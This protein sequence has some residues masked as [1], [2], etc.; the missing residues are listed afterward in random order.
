MFPGTG[1]DPDPANIAPFAANAN[2][3]V[4]IQIGPDGN[5]YYVDFDQGRIFRIEYGLQA[6]ATAA[7]TAGPVP[8]TVNF[9]GSGS[10]R[11]ARDALTYAWDLMATASTR[12]GAAEGRAPTTSAGT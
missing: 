4:D 9:D 2:G 12:L 11:P 1:G 6:V 5:F 8:L 3:P 10:S 7:P